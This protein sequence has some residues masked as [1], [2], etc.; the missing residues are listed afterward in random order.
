MNKLSVFLFVI[1]AFITFNLT[2][3]Q[4][5]SKEE[6]LE[7]ERLE[8]VYDKDEPEFK[9]TECPEQW[10]NESAVILAQKVYYSFSKK[11]IYNLRCSE[12][13]RKRI[14]L[15][16]K[17]AVEAF[18][19]FYFIST[20]DVGFQHIKPGKEPIY[21]DMKEAVSV[22][23][24][25]TIPGVYKSS[26]SWNK[27]YK[28][29]AIPDLEPGDI[30][31]FFYNVEENPYIGP[32]QEYKF[33][34]IIFS[35]HNT[36]PTVNQKIEFE[37]EK[38]FF[39]NINNTNGAPQLK[40]E[41]SPAKKTKMFSLV[42]KMREKEKKE[43][44]SYVYR[45]TP[46][47]KFQVL[48]LKS[49]NYKTTYFTGEI[50]VPKTKVPMQEV[51]EKISRDAL[52]IPYN[53]HTGKI[54]AYLSK[55]HKKLTDPVEIAKISYYY[56]RYSRFN[57]LGRDEYYT[58]R[59]N[60]EFFCKVLISVFNAKKVPY[61]LI[62]AV[63]RSIG[64]LD[65]MVL[66]REL[67]WFLKVEGSKPL[68]IHTL[69]ATSNVNE[70]LALLEGVDAYE[71][72]VD[73][74][75]KNIS[76]KKIQLPVTKEADN[77]HSETLDVSLK[78]M[79]FLTIKRE[80]QLTGY[81]KE[82]YLNY[83]LLKYDVQPED[84]HYFV[85]KDPE[86]SYKPLVREERARKRAEIQEEDEEKRIER[87][88]KYSESDF[89]IESY[90]NF[91]L[92]QTGRSMEKPELIFNEEFKVKGLLKKAGLN[93]MLD[94]GKLIG[95]QVELQEDEYERTHDVYMFS[96]RSYHYNITLNLP[97]GYMAEGV[98]KLNFT[99]DNETGSFISSAKVEGNKIIISAQKV[100][101]SN[102]VKKEDWGK[103]VAFLDGAFDF[104]N[105]KILL[106]KII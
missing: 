55:N 19:E 94:A 86:L 22:S 35:L 6:R 60:D 25:V 77:R 76:A 29:L 68:Y 99:I 63:P 92:V 80:I 84:Q 7:R 46:T 53:L 32:Y 95:S 64:S 43:R 66:K 57:D 18:S 38:L 87:L 82:N 100:Y 36:Y 42:D 33:S 9:L 97:D 50:G 58:S 15:N 37:V 78:D 62:V 69:S 65:E 59:L 21:V 70:F 2:A 101:K 102:F 89:E 52:M 103:M 105:T 4:K 47:I 61:K 20:T 3:Q 81:L 14:L 26:Y 28:K 44:W 49:P 16:D 30:I 79:E 91:A 51:A 73:K 96:A 104:C 67:N 5:E 40:E 11:N 8:A 24:S 93:Y 12:L 17:A 71:I 13:L 31:D 88:K 90:D 41:D 48:W 75:P 45:S 1:C 98:E 23:S 27:E 39:I 83:V 10:K 85:G 72:T 34:E 106:K 54:L 74:K 56:L